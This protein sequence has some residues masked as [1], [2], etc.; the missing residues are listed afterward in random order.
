MK[1]FN[2]YLA[3]DNNGQYKNKLVNIKIIKFVNIKNRLN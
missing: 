2:I 1:C 3:N